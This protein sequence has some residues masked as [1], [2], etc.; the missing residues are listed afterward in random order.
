[1]R[2][3]AAIAWRHLAD[4][5]EVNLAEAEASSTRAG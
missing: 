4:D 2:Q 5:G 3:L 1:M